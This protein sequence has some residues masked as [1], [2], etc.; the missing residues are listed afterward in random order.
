MPIDAED[1][2]DEVEHSDETAP[3][4]PE[5]YEGIFLLRPEELEAWPSDWHRDQNMAGLGGV[6]TFAGERRVALLTGPRRTSL[7][8][9][10]ALARL[11]PN[12]GGLW[13]KLFNKL[14]AP[15][16][17]TAVPRL[18]ELLIEAQ[19][20]APREH[21]LQPRFLNRTLP[22]PRN[23]EWSPN[24]SESQMLPFCLRGDISSLNPMAREAA[25]FTPLLGGTSL[26]PLADYV[27]VRETNAAWAC[28]PFA[29][30]LEVL[31]PRARW[32]DEVTLR[33]ELPDGAEWKAM[34]ERL[35]G[36]AVGRIKHGDEFSK[37]AQELNPPDPDDR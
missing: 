1:L 24:A 31:G 35:C 4:A 16:P 20:L 36:A 11:A 6:L 12:S 30:L 10:R 32:L 18:V 37:S 14:P 2:P 7:I 22:L 8:G 13:S 19:Q 17:Q 26:V 5:G 34:S 25:S 29:L 23:A 33:A 9:A 15:D 3:K 21:A 27:A 28:A